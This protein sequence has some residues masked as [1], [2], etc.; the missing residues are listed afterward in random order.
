MENLHYEQS[1]CFQKKVLKK[2]LEASSEK[3]GFDANIKIHLRRGTEFNHLVFF[4]PR[5]IS[6]WRITVG[7]S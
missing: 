4:E 7:N 1:F 2:S 5:Q 6:E 3:F